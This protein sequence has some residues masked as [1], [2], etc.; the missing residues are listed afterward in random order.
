MCI[1]PAPTVSY[2]VVLLESEKIKG[3]PLFP[4]CLYDSC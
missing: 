2:C 1:E 4:S 3:F